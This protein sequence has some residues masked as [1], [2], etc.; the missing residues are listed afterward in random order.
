MARDTSFD[1]LTDDLLVAFVNVLSPLDGWGRIGS[2]PSVYPHLGLPLPQ[3]PFPACYLDCSM[4]PDYG[5]GTS[6]RRDLYT[7][8]I[9]MIGGPAT[10]GYKFNPEVAVNQMLTA[11]V[12]E[13]DYRPF[14]QDPSNNNTPFRYLDP[15]GKVAVLDTGRTRAFSYS[16][17][18]NY[19]GRELTVS[20]GLQVNVGRI[21]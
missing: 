12:N 6:V 2:T 17:Q 16:D 5:Q 9:R 10:P 11:V 4:R 13:L 7:V 1:T 8:F 15:A 18:G 3:E 20:V 21:S 19:I 14:L